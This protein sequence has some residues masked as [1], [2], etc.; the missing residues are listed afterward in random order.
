[1]ET[2][3]TCPDHECD[4]LV[5]GAGPAGL[6]AAINGASEGLSVIVLDRYTTLGGQASTSSRIENYLGFPEGLSGAELTA[7]AEAQ[8]RRFGAVFH[9]GAEVI[10]LRADGDAHSAMCANGHVYRCRTVLVTT[11]VTY[12]RL[13]VPG[14]EAL[15]GRGVFYGASPSQAYEYEGK[16]VFVVGGANSAGQAALHLAAHGARVDIV[17]RSPLVKSMSSYLLDRLTAAPAD[18][19]VTTGGRIAAVRGQDDVLS[20]VTVAHPGGVV[21]HEAAAVFVFIGAD[22]LTDWAPHLAKDEKGFVLTGPDAQPWLS[23]NHGYELQL[24]YLE[25]SV[26]GTFAAGDIRSGSVK[27]VAAAAGEGSMAVQFVHRYLS[28][29]KEY[30]RV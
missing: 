2:C 20:H 3:S 1:M 25:T 21:S 30:T 9:P 22:P 29:Q 5:I 6:A 11:G 10:D 12:R 26:P 23:G 4:L 24:L 27:R 17:T 15:L 18:I 19:S 8:A 7:Q 13:T 28:R 16:R 14:A